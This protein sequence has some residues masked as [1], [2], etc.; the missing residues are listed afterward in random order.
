L[1]EIV[2]PTR[3]DFVTLVADQRDARRFGGRLDEFFRGTVP[4]S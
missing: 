1:A 3:D 2:D 4:L